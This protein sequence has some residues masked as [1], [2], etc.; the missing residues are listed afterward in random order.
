MIGADKMITVLNESGGFFVPTII[1]NVTWVEKSEKLPTEKG[2]VVNRS[3]TIR[4]PVSSCPQGKKF[5]MPYECSKNADFNA[6]WSARPQKD[7]V[8][9][10]EIRKVDDITRILECFNTATPVMVKDNRIGSP[11][12][13]HIRIDCK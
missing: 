5:V 3:V 12:V 6:V 1:N 13:Q 11:F 9:L 4:I 8:V 2:L 10:G 7:L